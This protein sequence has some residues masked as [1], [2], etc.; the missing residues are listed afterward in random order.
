M[1]LSWSASAQAI[2]VRFDWN[3]VVDHVPLE[4]LD[5]SVG[6]SVQIA[7]FGNNGGVSLLD[8]VWNNASITH[9]SLTAGAYTATYFPPSGV[10]DPIFTSDAGGL[11][12]FSKEIFTGPA[13]ATDVLDG[14]TAPYHS[15]NSAVTSTGR[16]FFWDVSFSGGY[17]TWNPSQWTVSRVSLPEPDTL[18]LLTMGL[19]GSAWVRRRNVAQQFHNPSIEKPSLR[20]FSLF[21]RCP[22]VA[23]RFYGCYGA[24]ARGC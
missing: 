14:S 23:G 7:V 10:G 21:G 13:T 2:P 20:R 19:A 8:Q 24:S 17:D 16:I 6:T 22:L 9:A 18:L 15:R 1:L 12:S 11:I 4:V 5:V 3:G